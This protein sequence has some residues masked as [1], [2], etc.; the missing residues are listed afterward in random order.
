MAKVDLLVKNGEVW[1]PGGF[2]Q[3]DIAVTDGKVIALG[4]P[5][6]LPDE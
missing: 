3:A 1:T 2:V 5:P 6:F 4:K